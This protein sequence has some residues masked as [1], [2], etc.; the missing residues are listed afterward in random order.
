[1]TFSSSGPEYRTFGKG[2]EG[3]SHQVDGDRD[4]T[5]RTN[6]LSL[7]L[8]LCLQSVYFEDL[9]GNKQLGGY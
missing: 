7:S 2:K 9:G 6:D 3:S 4:G 8:L 5:E 1:M